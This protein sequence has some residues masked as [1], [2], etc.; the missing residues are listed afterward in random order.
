MQA[1]A[2]AAEGGRRDPSRARTT[3]SRNG[4]SAAGTV[5]ELG[6]TGLG[7]STTCVTWQARLH[8]HG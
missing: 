7:K 6:L 1:P 4:E 3:R 2:T 8:I 5:L